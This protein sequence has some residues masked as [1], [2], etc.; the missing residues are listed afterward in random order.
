LV[1]AAREL[2][3]S[4]VPATIIAAAMLISTWPHSFIGL[5]SDSISYLRIAT[6]LSPFAAHDAVARDV[7]HSTHF[8]PGYPLVLGLLGGTQAHAQWAYGIHCLLFAATVVVVAWFF[9]SELNERRAAQVAT[10]V[11]VLS[12]AWLIAGLRLSSEP[13]FACLLLSGLML[14]LRQRIRPAAA[15]LGLSCLVRAAGLAALPAL[16][17]WLLADRERRRDVV[18]PMALAVAP[19]CALSLLRL[20]VSGSSNYVSDVAVVIGAIAGGKGLEFLVQQGAALLSALSLALKPEPASIALGAVLTLCV[21][22]GWWQ[23][24]R[25]GRL[26]AYVLPCYLALI[27]VWPYPAEMP[28]FVSPVTPLIVLSACSSLSLMP[29]RRSLGAAALAAWPLFLAGGVIFRLLYPGPAELAPYKASDPYYLAA[30]QTKAVEF[31]S[32]ARS[33]DAALK[34]VPEVVPQDACVYSVVPELAGFLAGRRF[35]SPAPGAPTPASVAQDFPQCDFFFVSLLGPAQRSFPAYYPLR[36]VD[37]ATRR[38]FLTTFP[39]GEKNVLSAA[40]LVKLDRTGTP[41]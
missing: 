16:A 40:L 19:Y 2:A 35:V 24:F 20:S 7:F 32:L 22:P 27:A 38:V 5:F 3:W 13:L 29:R 26:D 31:L 14:A 18:A 8:P 1:A 10:L 37:A 30:N 39:Q 33:F 12:P 6:Y 21:V 4:I 23:R 9:R 41:K 28:R 15:V 25:A 17:L 34:A 11:T 36:Q